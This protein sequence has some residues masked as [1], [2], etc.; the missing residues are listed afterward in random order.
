MQNSEIYRQGIVLP[1]DTQAME[2]LRDN[3]VDLSTHIRVLKVPSNK[4]F[5][6]LLQLKLF[7]EINKRCTAIIDEY[8]EEWIDA[9]AVTGI[10][11]AI[12]AIE[13]IVCDPDTAR[14]LSELRTMA[15]DAGKMHRP[16][17]FVL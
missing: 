1:L 11:E 3:D 10:A 9:S 6:N 12:D 15:S 4:V 2:R 8:E 14:F 16:L 17:L 5:A 13:R 7:E